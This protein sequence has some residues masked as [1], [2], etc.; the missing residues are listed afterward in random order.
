[1]VVPVVSD[2]GLAQHLFPE[3]LQ[4][5]FSLVVPRV[6]HEGAVVDLER[7]GS[8]AETHDRATPIEVVDDVLHLLGGEVLEP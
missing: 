7:M 1:M 6:L 4:I 8:G 2:P 3:S 5:L